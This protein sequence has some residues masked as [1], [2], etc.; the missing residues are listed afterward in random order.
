MRKKIFYWL[1]KEFV[2]ISCE[3][4]AGRTA[5]EQAQGIFRRMEDELRGSG[6]SLP[7]TVRTRLWGKDRAS[8]NEGSDERV[9]ILSG[10]ARSVSSSYIAPERFD[11]EALVA[12]DLLAMRP[13]QAGAQKT[14][15]EY[16]PPITPLR[17]LVYDSVVFLSGVT[18]V[19]PTLREQMADILPRITG[20]LADAGSDW[21]RVVKVSFFLHRSQTKE[22]L[23]KLFREAVK[24]AV[25]VVEFGFVDGYSSEGKL[26][27][28]EVTAR[29]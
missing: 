23:E 20:S 5:A 27:E 15:K 26:I 18:A 10:S 6:L 17:Y 8:R 1:G 13:S 24:T 7:N 4:V 14:L 25:P 3:G 2:A 12:L 19:L 28:I 9:G 11:S 21:E 16:E 22:A 29:R